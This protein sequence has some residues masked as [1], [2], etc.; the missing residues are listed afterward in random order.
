MRAWGRRCA[1]CAAAGLAVVAFPALAPAQLVPILR[2]DVEENVL[3]LPSGRPGRAGE[4]APAGTAPAQTT[5]AATGLPDPGR[6]AAA[7]A[8]GTDLS[9]QLSGPSLFDDDEAAADGDADAIGALITGSVD[10]FEEDEPD[11]GRVEAVAPAGPVQARAVSD[12]TAPYAPLGLRV[13]T[14]D[15]TTTLDLGA[16]YLRTTTAFNDPGP[17]AGVRETTSEGTFGEAALSVRAGSDWARHALDLGFDGRLPFRISGDE[18]QSASFGADAALRLDIDRD[19][20][21]TAS[22]GYSYTQDDPGSAAV[23]EAIDP[24]RFPGVGTANEP[25]VQTFDGALTLSRQAGNLRGL[26]EINGLRQTVGDA[27]LSNGTTIPQDDLDYT[28]YGGRLRGGYAISPVLTPFVE[29]EVSRRVMDER[30]D[31]SGLDRNALRYA[32]RLGTA[33]DRGEKLSGEVAIGY[34]R[35]DIADAALAD[36]AG[37]SVNADLRWSPRRETDV[38]FGLATVTTTSSA[39][40]TSG[41]LIYAANLGVQHRARANLELNGEVSV[42]YEDVVGPDEDTVTAAGLVGATYWFNRFMGLTGRVGHERTFSDDPAEETRSS[43]VFV[44]VRL[45]R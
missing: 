14:F 39:A 18:D 10:P 2:G 27:R 34:V 21:L 40:D 3:G 15:V 5:G 37:L 41:S 23:F 7:G 33:F 43:N 28:R 22:G 19:T 45:Q 20:V 36:I 16:T 35:E 25:V 30:P 13:G 38:R 4:T 26:A 29:V 31:T 44:G 9:T 8:A 11:F 42:Q 1:V 24:I 6:D 32:L 17:P 12:E